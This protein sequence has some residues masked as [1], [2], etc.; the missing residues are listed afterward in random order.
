MSTATGSTARRLRVQQS[1]VD[2]GTTADR[3][4]P[5][6]ALNPATAHT[7]VRNTP[8][9][10]DDEIANPKTSPQ[11]NATKIVHK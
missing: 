11:A 8:I 10:K 3:N 1:D 6:R 2:G 4:N 9:P 7:A 5:S